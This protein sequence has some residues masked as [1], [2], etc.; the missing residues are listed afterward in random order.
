MLTTNKPG[1]IP[2]HPLIMWKAN[3]VIFFAAIAVRFLVQHG[4]N[5]DWSIDDN[6][7]E[8]LK[9][10]ATNMAPFVAFL[11]AMQY[12]DGDSRVSRA[13]AL[14]MALKSKRDFFD[15]VPKKVVVSLE[16]PII[17][18]TRTKKPLNVIEMM[19]DTNLHAR[20]AEHYPN[21]DL[22]SFLDSI[23]S[24]TYELQS[25]GNLHPETTAFKVV[26]FFIMVSYY[27][28]LMPIVAAV[29]GMSLNSWSLYVSIVV[30]LLPPLVYAVIEL[31]HKMRITQAQKKHR[32]ENLFRFTTSVGAS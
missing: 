11:L 17:G 2:L 32:V 1:T 31:G 30:I 26:F 14:Y 6:D 3:L 15:H 29:P 28:L 12:Q 5:E 9:Q 16:G 20:F 25:L 27:A 8:S 7:I 24:D 21:F 18:G 4:L 22:L 23:S 10:M 13:H 19:A